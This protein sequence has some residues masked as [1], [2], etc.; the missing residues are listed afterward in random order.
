M[1]LFR[2]RFLPFFLLNYYCGSVVIYKMD[3]ERNIAK[4]WTK[5]LRTAKKQAK[6]EG[7]WNNEVVTYIAST[8]KL[9]LL[10]LTFQNLK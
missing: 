8:C 6:Q 10:A 5:K 7:K 2:M 3:N 9:S 1:L 4:T